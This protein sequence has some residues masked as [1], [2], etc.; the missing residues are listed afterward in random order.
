MEEKKIPIGKKPMIYIYPPPIKNKISI[1][2]AALSNMG[3]FKS[4]LPS[5]IEAQKNLQKTF[6]SPEIQNAIMQINFLKKTIDFKA[7]DKIRNIVVMPKPAY[8]KIMPIIPTEVYIEKA[9]KEREDKMIELLTQIVHNTTAV[10]YTRLTVDEIDTFYN[11]STVKETDVMDKVPLQLEEKIVK[12][13]LHEIIGDPFIQKDW[14][15]EKS[16][17]FTFHIQ[18]RNKK[19]SAAFLLKGKSYTRQKLSLKDLGKNAD[20]LCRLF[21]LPAEI[22]FIQSNGAVDSAIETTVQAFMAKKINEGV[23]AYYCIID[24][25]D[26]VRILSAY[27]KL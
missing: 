2:E 27:N 15:G 5:I 19:T 4:I 1:G 12:K 14:A 9:R 23:K 24:G 6:N 26:T 11:V 10:Q 13:M 8:E 21:G 3:P 16:D 17:I 20:Q 18:F 25:I 22:Y 7:L